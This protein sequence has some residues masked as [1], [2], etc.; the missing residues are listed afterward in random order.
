V[1]QKKA[2]NS[3]A[4]ARASGEL[5]KE[6]SQQLVHAREISHPSI[7]LVAAHGVLESPARQEFCQLRKDAA[8]LVHGRIVATIDRLTR[9]KHRKKLKSCTPSSV[10]KNRK[11]ERQME[12]L[13]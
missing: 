8:T 13:V 3:L 10:Q 11:I 9:Q 12:F 5:G 1:D 6:Q 4:Q 2:R 7:A